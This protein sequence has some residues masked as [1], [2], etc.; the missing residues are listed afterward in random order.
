MRTAL[1]ALSAMFILATPV[2]PA[3]AAPET[4]QATSF[5]ADITSLS[6]AGAGSAGSVGV[7]AWRLDGKGPVTLVNADV[8]YPMASTFKVAV[9]GAVLKRVRTASSSSTR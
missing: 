7:A 6:K 3:Q 4:A 2:A 8:A 5:A 1:A 9:A